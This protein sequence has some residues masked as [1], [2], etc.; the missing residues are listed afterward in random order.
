MRVLKVKF[1]AIYTWYDE[2]SEEKIKALEKQAVCKE[3]I[4]SVMGGGGGM[5]QSWVLPRIW[6]FVTVGRSIF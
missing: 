4:S 3:L 2:G 6:R 5:P 1:K